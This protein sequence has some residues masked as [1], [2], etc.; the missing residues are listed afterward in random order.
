M[1]WNELLSKKRFKE[2]QKNDIVYRNDYDTIICS[3]LFRRLQDKAQVFPLDDDDYVRTR[4]THSLEVSA[5]G[6]KLGE[7]VFGTIK[8]MKI[9][10][11][12]DTHTEKDFSDVLLC[13]GLIHDIGN[14]PFGH[15]GEYAIRE[16]FQTNLDR[17]FLGRRKITEILTKWQLQ[18]LY[19]FEGNAQ[20]LRLLSKTPYLG[21][22]DGFNLSYEVLGTIMKY[23]ISSEALKNDNPNQYKKT[24]YNFSERELFEDINHT[25]GMN[26][27]RHPLSYLLE[28][29]DD[30]AYRTSD[31]EDAMV[32]KVINFQQITDMLQQ[33]KIGFND[34]DI[35]RNDIRTCTDR[36]LGI[37]QEELLKNG[38]KPELTAV[39]RWN[40]HIQGMMIKDAGDAFIKNYEQIM[41]GTFKGNL[42]EHTVSGY[43]ILAVSE[44]SE[45]LI[46]T[47]S[48]KTRTELFG[49]R[50]IDSLLGQFMPA[51]I[52][53]DTEEQITFIEQRTMD[54]VS[55]FYKSMY[56]SEADGKCEQE[57]L[58]LRLLMITDYISG[59]T[60][61]YA[62][63]LYQELFA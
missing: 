13:A 51:A 44:L 63:R 54:T 21:R 25:M 6:K 18:D 17:L 29:A 30:I 24:G 28:A 15:F 2:E 50:V 26:G 10:D 58:Y 27:N 52:V 57:K 59:M 16:W 46:Y 20:S 31:L 1:E 14:P 5:I 7:Y 9:D 38:R 41:Q 43:L 23:P 12:F 47:S 35:C 40:Q 62:K 33:D 61:N 34:K 55:E 22:K 8:K 19:S 39:Q 3:T 60:D 32:K 56:H 53:Y 36:L 48:I 11:W 4:L 37:Y 45:R 49:R 42:F